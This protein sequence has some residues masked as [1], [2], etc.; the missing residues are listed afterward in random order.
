MAD[1]MLPVHESQVIELARQ[2][3]PEGR[4]AVL[5]ALIPDLDQ[6]EALVDYGDERIRALCAERGIDWDSLSEEKREQLIDD[7]L[8][9]E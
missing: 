6:F 9:E 4:R 8:H 7:L 2:L 5:R 3:S 1:V